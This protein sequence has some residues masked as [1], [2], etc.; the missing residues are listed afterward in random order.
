MDIQNSLQKQEE[1]S[2][3]SWRC[4][5]CDRPSPSPRR[6]TTSP[7]N[8]Q[9][10]GRHVRESAVR[11]FVRELHHQWKENKSSP[12]LVEMRKW[13]CRSNPCHEYENNCRKANPEYCEWLDISGEEK[14]MKKI[15]KELD[16]VIM[17]W[18]EEH[19]SKRIP[20]QVKE[21]YFMDVM[22]SLIENTEE[23]DADTII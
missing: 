11:E 16:Q 10:H 18:L 22:L 4:T 17:E 6:A 9:H 3:L 7:H 15:A 14:A 5:P 1:R 8:P 23:N 12:A 13:F 20:G 2:A 19:K 21:E